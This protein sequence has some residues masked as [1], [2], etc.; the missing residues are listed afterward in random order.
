MGNIFY[1]YSYKLQLF[2]RA[3]GFKY[4]QTGKEKNTQ[5][6]YWE[7]VKSEKLDKAISL[8]NDVKLMFS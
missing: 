1:C 5:N 2:L 7:F 3:L 8:Y 4:I 6:T